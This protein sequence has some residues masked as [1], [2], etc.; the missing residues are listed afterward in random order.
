MSTPDLFRSR[1]AQMID[2]SAAVDA[3]GVTLD[4]TQTRQ[5]RLWRQVAACE[6]QALAHDTAVDLPVD[7]REAEAE[8][9][10]D[11]RPAEL[12]LQQRLDRRWIGA[13]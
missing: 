8:L 5:G 7:S 3:D 12:G 4:A 10:G 9:L 1:L 11:G 13:G 2:R 6:L